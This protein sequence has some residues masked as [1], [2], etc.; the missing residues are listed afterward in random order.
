MLIISKTYLFRRS[1]ALSVSHLTGPSH[2]R[3]CL[4][5]LVCILTASLIKVIIGSVTFLLT[6][7]SF[8]WLVGWSSACLN[9]PKK[10]IKR[11]VNI[12]DLTKAFDCLYPFCQPH[13]SC[14]IR[15]CV[16]VISFENSI[17]AIAGLTSD[18]V[19]I[20][21]LT[22]SPL[23]PFI[24]PSTPPSPLLYLCFPLVPP[25]PHFP[26]ESPFL[27]LPP[28]PPLL[29]PPSPSQSSP[30]SLSN[31]PNAQIFNHSPPSPFPSSS[32]L[33]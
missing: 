27:F 25:F 7:V 33:L 11:K 24:L 6:F 23:S 15:V 29:F 3:H 17:H 20:I 22:A 10:V 12:S 21:V 19:S 31:L 4:S 16:V 18:F 13:P 1:F 9:C 32:F 14:E 28:Y 5:I 26:L 30:P 2:L 8:F